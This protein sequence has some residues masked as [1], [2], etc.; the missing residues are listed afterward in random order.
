[1]DEVTASLW[2]VLG[3]MLDVVLVAGMS[4]GLGDVGSSSVWI[5]GSV[6]AIGSVVSG[7][8]LY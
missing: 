8:M 5:G 7:A 6:V 1:M 4:V 3:A 2:V